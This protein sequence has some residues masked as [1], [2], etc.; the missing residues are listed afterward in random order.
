M[1][2]APAGAQAPRDS[3]VVIAEAGV[4]GDYTNQIFYEQ[5][6]DSTAITGRL[7]V[8]DPV[9]RALGLLYARI[10][11]AQGRLSFDAANDLGAGPTLL[12]DALRGAARY[13]LGGGWRAEA[14]GEFDVRRDDT[15]ELRREDR[16]AAGGANLRWVGPGFAT[17]ARVFGRIEGL[18]SAEGTLAL[19]PDYDFR[20]VGFEVDRFGIAGQGSLT[21]AYGERAFP[22]TAARDYREHALIGDGRVRLTD[23]LRLEGRGD[24]VR[25]LAWS[26]SAVGDRFWNGDGELAL[27]AAPDERFEFGPLAR[28]RVLDYDEPTP[29][30]FNVTLYRY[31]VFARWL[32]DFARRYELRP[33][34]EFLRTP[35]YGG[36]PK[37]T[38]VADLRAVASEEYD[39]WS[40]AGE[41]ESMGATAWFFGTVAGGARQYSDGAA[42]A[43]NL[44]AH[45][46]FWFLEASGF[47]ERRLSS[48]L[49]V[50]ASADARIEFHSVEA[51]DLTSLFFAL[52]LRTPLGK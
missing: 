18:R 12:R 36:L 31:G 22:D 23:A 29:T 15:F 38:S 37:G 40:L 47:G 49:R 11:G 7:T 13:A 24:G 26:D 42:D 35:A 34:I 32:P 33:E 39:Q 28:L 25:R 52:E 10:A 41:A 6:F 20:Q 21:Y 16:R 3:V 44:S 9:S 17:S 43:R 14:T 2:A 8:S 45:S 27:V 30:F 4:G 51:D 46:D 50:R 48:R 5:T 1:C 19:F